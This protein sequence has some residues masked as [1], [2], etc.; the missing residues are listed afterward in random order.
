MTGKR[1]LLVLAILWI[2]VL[3]C[4]QALAQ[5]APINFANPTYCQ[6][7]SLSASTLVSTCP[8]GIPAGTVI[9]EIC[10]ESQ[11]IRYRDDGTAPTASIGMPVAVA[12]CF[13]YTGPVSKLAIIQQASAATVNITFYSIP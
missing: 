4:W 6:L 2:A 8:G 11:A 9:T 1:L 10:V 3:A 5:P 12:V 13:A 7:T